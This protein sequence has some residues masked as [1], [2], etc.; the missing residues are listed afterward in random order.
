[1]TS[2]NLSSGVIRLYFIKFQHNTLSLTLALIIS[3]RSN[4]SHRSFVKA[5]KYDKKFTI[6]YHV[7]LKIYMLKFTPLPVYFPLFIKNSQLYVIWY[8]WGH[9]NIST[10][11]DT[12]YFAIFYKNSHCDCIN[13]IGNYHSPSLHLCFT[14]V[15]IIQP[16]RYTQ[17]TGFIFLGRFY[18]HFGNM[19]PSHHYSYYTWFVLDI[20][21]VLLRLCYD[22]HYC[23]YN[24]YNP[25]VDHKAIFFF[26]WNWRA[27]WVF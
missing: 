15:I 2:Q 7:L 20:I 10:F 18:S 12:F 26:H 16:N 3:M 17:A 4:E 23:L 11:F 19:F 1:M 14:T 27:S 24:N 21:V 6:F 8:L 9:S 13:L 22:Y 25:T 5:S